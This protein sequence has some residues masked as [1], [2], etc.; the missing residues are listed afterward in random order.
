QAVHAAEERQLTR[1]GEAH[2]HADLAFLDRDVGVGDADQGPWPLEER[3]ALH[4]PSEQIER[5]RG[6]P[7]EHYV[8]VSE[9]VRGHAQLPA[10]APPR[11]LH[12]RS[13]RMATSTMA[14]PASKPWAMLTVLSARTTGLP[15]P[16]APTRAAITTMDSDSMMHCVRPAMMVGMACGSSTFH[17]CWRR[18]APN[19]SPAS[20][21]GFGAEDTPR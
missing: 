2:K 12:T 1:A 14:S 5:P 20:I 18:V 17:R 8:D 10:P 7:A 13:S 3:L 9:L 16:P 19:A 11:R 6:A 21:S 4:T 15:R